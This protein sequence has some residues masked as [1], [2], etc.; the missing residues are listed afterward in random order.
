MDPGLISILMSAHLTKLR[1]IKI[2]ILNLS[3]WHSGLLF[4]RISI[5][6]VKATLE[7]MPAAERVS[8]QLS[9]GWRLQRPGHRPRCPSEEV[10]GYTVTAAP[11]NYIPELIGYWTKNQQNNQAQK[12]NDWRLATVCRQ[13]GA[14]VRQVWIARRRGWRQEAGGED[15][16]PAVT[17]P[18]RNWSIPRQRSSLTPVTPSLLSPDPWLCDDPGSRQ[19]LFWYFIRCCCCCQE[20]CKSSALCCG[21]GRLNFKL[22]WKVSL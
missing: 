22:S 3:F 6:G 17:A 19:S 4:C 16:E 10:R 15:Q 20:F 7:Q 2:H 14:S 1:R 18:D 12:A 9:G 5:W 21:N 13:W 8:K 11:C